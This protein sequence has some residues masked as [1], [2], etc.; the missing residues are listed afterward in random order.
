MMNLIIRYIPDLEEKEYAALFKIKNNLTKNF[1]DYHRQKI[2]KSS[3][4]FYKN[5]TVQE[6]KIIYKMML[7]YPD[8]AKDMIDSKMNSMYLFC[9]H[10]NDFHQILDLDYQ[11]KL[12]QKV[13]ELQLDEMFLFVQE[14]MPVYIKQLFVYFKKQDPNYEFILNGFQD[15]M[16]KKVHDLTFK[17]ILRNLCQTNNIE[18]KF[19]EEKNLFTISDFVTHNFQIDFKMD[20][21]LEKIMTR[22]PKIDH[23]LSQKILFRLTNDVSSVMY[24]FLEEHQPKIEVKSDK[25]HIMINGNNI[26]GFSNKFQFMKKYLNE[27]IEKLIQIQGKDE[28]K[29]FIEQQKF[30]Y[31]QKMI[32]E[33]LEIQNDVKIKKRKI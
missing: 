14:K 30:I 20:L 25:I 7:K 12:Y 28:Q 31:E 1:Q 8:F 3:I 29:Q 19:S 17:A 24:N 23:Q 10:L 15:I 18:V 11:K 9:H 2:K 13:K 33:S 32:E 22:E 26:N 4:I 21:L 16:P 5:Y 6:E 27:L